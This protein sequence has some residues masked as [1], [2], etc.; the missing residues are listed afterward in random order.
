MHQAIRHYDL[1][2]E[3]H[4]LTHSSRAVN[5]CARTYT[6]VLIGPSTVRPKSVTLHYIFASMSSMCFI[7]FSTLACSELR[8][9]SCFF[10]RSSDDTCSIHVYVYTYMYIQYVYIYIYIYIYTYIY[11]Y[12]YI[13]T[14]PCFFSRSSDDTCSIHAYAYICMY[15]RAYFP[16]FL[17]KLLRLYLHSTSLCFTYVCTYFSLFLVTLLG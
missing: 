8:A 4:P 17:L 5:T 10:S 9:C 3:I 11:I 15:I 2:V 14:F 16:L 7:S 13:C 6:Q 1:H 12:I